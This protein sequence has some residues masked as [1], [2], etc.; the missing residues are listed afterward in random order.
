MGANANE[1]LRASEIQSQDYLIEE[2]PCNEW[3][4]SAIEM[5]LKHSNIDHSEREDIERKML[6][7]SEEEAYKT[8]EYLRENQLNRISSGFPYS[9]SDI[10]KQQQNFNK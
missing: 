3:Q 10:T 7:F 2:S 4:I 9:Q 8:I 5:L 1:F 6:S